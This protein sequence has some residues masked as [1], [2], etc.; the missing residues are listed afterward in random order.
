[1]YIY[2]FYFMMS[3]VLVFFLF[4]DLLFFQLLILVSFILISSLYL[5]FF[6]SSWGILLILIGVIGGLIVLFSFISMSFPNPSIQQKKN[7][8]TMLMM[9]MC[10]F[11]LSLSFK[12]EIFSSMFFF[13]YLSELNSMMCST[14]LTNSII[15]Y[16]YY[17]MFIFLIFIL[18]MMLFVVDQISSSKSGNMIN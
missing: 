2:F 12:N 7:S 16:P 18:L 14:T 17:L 1:M 15:F 9:V 10:V 5:C 13:P 6:L 4:T 8:K 3:F 11:F